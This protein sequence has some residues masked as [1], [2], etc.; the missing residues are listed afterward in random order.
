MTNLS[1]VLTVR[2]R[3]SCYARRSR[4]C[5]RRSRQNMTADLRAPANFTSWSRTTVPIASLTAFDAS[6]SLFRAI[7]AM[8]VP[9]SELPPARSGPT[10][11]AR[12][13]AE[14][15]GRPSGTRPVSGGQEPDIRRRHRRCAR[16]CVH[17][18]WASAP[19][20]PV[21][22][23][24]L[25]CVR[26]CL[27]VSFTDNCSRT[28]VYDVVNLRWT[29]AGT[30]SGYVVGIVNVNAHGKA[31]LNKTGEATIFADGTMI[32]PDSRVNDGAQRAPSA[33]RS[34]L[35]WR[36]LHVCVQSRVATTD[37]SC[38]CTEDVR[39]RARTCAVRGR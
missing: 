21:G 34:R 36:S 24:A 13:R 14:R 12:V 35:V 1:S 17:A 3:H 4:W 9:T 28:P 29:S 2:R 27:Q 30:M 23:P 33:A 31:E 16:R 19:A 7:H 18:R 10:H 39:P 6:F 25:T 5:T 26:T 38:T 37:S 20:A 32:P 15:R 22:L 11:E 8:L